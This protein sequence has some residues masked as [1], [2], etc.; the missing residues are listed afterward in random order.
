MQKKGFRSE[1]TFLGMLG[2]AGVLLLLTIVLLFL[3]ENVYYETREAKLKYMDLPKSQITYTEQVA[4]TLLIWEEQDDR[5]S[6]GRQLM[7]DVLSQMKEPYQLCESNELTREKMQSYRRIVLAV[8]HLQNLSDQIQNLRN[9]VKEGGN[10]MFLYVPE[11][12]GVLSSV[13]NM[14]GCK[15]CSGQMAEVSGLHFNQDFMLGGTIKNY[16]IMDPFESS[17]SMALYA[18]CQI[19]LQSNDEYPVPLIWSNAFGKGKV[20]VDNLEIM[21]KS[22]R[23]FHCAAYTLL[24]EACI[25]PVINASTFYIDDFPSPV[26]GGNAEYITRDFDMSISEFYTQKWWPDVYN[27]AQDYGI[28]YTGLVIEEYNDQVKGPFERN[29]E[30]ERY[31]YFGN[32]LLEADGEIGIHG[33]NHM[34][35][36]LENFDYKDQYDSYKQWPGSQ[37]IKEAF[38]EVYDFTKELYPDQEIQT[39]VPPSNILSEEARDI[40]AKDF[41]SIKGIAAV[42]I[43]GDLGYAQEFNVGE[44]GIVNTPRIISGYNLNDFTD[45]TALSELTFHYCNTHFQHPDDVLDEDRG[46][47]LGWR[48]LFSR[49]KNYVIWLKKAAGDL[50]DLTGSELSAAVQRYDYI[51]VERKETAQGMDISLQNFYDEAYFLLRINTECEQPQIKGGSLKK[52]GE[53]LYL[54]KADQAELQLIYK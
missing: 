45:L 46:A 25:Y 27:L 18:D 26:P 31:E 7:E 11:Y 14:M 23:G 1:I 17:M 12:N 20:V 38:G 3:Q 52:V 21:E 39:Y 53:N 33:Y 43:E 13:Y 10:L 32:M 48:T 40:I 24:D 54:V 42:Y 4:K 34:P 15:D 35:L 30:T 9:W 36:V 29:K 2:S 44:D 5:S 6:K 47:A 50:R 19:Y 8:S 41:P 37:E 22:Y 16:T 28:S 49:L 51:D